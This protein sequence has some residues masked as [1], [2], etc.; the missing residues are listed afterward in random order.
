[1]PEPLFK[2]SYCLDRIEINEGKDNEGWFLSR[3]VSASVLK[4]DA[5]LVGPKSFFVKK[6]QLQF[7]AFS[8]MFQI[9][10]VRKRK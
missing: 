6:R 2:I 1:M 4:P 8:V 5:L 10:R 7:F 3:A 9:Q